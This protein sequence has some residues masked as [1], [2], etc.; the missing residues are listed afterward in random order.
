MKA[1]IDAIATLGE[2]DYISSYGSIYYYERYTFNGRNVYLRFS[3]HSGYG[4]ELNDNIYISIVFTKC[5][6][7]PTYFEHN[8]IN[9]FEF[10]FDYK[11]EF[12]IVMEFIFNFVKKL[13][14]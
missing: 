2:P 10:F 6:Y 11:T 4:N 5:D 13:T 3:D 14:N 8:N 9:D 7:S 12:E 1:I